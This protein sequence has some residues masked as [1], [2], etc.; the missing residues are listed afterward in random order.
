[1]LCFHPSLH[2]APADSK[3]SRL[4]A[5]VGWLAPGLVPTAANVSGYFVADLSGLL[6]LF[7]SRL[8]CWLHR[9]FD[10][11][12]AIVDTSLGGALRP[13]AAGWPGQG[14][15]RTTLSEDF[16]GSC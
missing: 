10:R 3:R 2:D 5:V 8:R 1:M 15:N 13:R 14:N 7:S 4:D 9:I 12:R 16:D 11:H 6:L